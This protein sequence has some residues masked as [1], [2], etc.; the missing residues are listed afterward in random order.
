MKVFLYALVA[1]IGNAL[2]VY[3][4]RAS[5]TSENPFYFLTLTLGVCIALFIASALLHKSPMD[6]LYARENL[7]LILI[8]GLGFFLTFMGFYWLYHQQ[9]AINYILYA[10]MSILTTSIGVGL[11]LFREPFNRV[12]VISGLLAVSAI[13][14][15][16]I[17][18]QRLSN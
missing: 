16:G 8:S 10:L 17:G 2:F 7:R 9:G 5:G 18:Q 12:H 13:V 3:G 6:L 14:F 1:A 11:I 4:Q 15:Y